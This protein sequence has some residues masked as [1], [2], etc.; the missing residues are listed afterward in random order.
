MRDQYNP[1]TSGSDPHLGAHRL[2][3]NVKPTHYGIRLEPDLEKASFEGSIDIHLDV[4]QESTFILLNAVELDILTTHVIAGGKYVK[5]PKVQYNE[6]QQTL[7]VPLPEPIQAGS[8]IQL[9]Q[10]FKGRLNDAKTMAGFNRSTYTGYDGKTKWIGSTQGQPTGARQIFPCMDEPNLKATFRATLTVDQ[11]LTCLS[12]MDIY[13]SSPTPNGKKNVYVF[14]KTPLMST[15]LIAF[16]VGELN[17]IEST[18][19]RVPIRFYATPDNVIQDGAFALDVGVKAMISHEK[20]FG[21]PYPLP[22][23]DMIAV[24]GRL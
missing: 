11:G 21:S 23:L 1:F 15:Y 2:P 16:V 20:T 19:Y 7:M 4:L 10:T 3:T 22:K 17:Y 12:N 5:V 8:K 9:R 13:S 18:T 24:P 6:A 14:N